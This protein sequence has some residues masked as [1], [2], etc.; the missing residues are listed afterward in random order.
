M[1]PI[2]VEAVEWWGPNF[3][4][5]EEFVG[6]DAELRDHRL[7]IATREGPLWANPHDWIIKSASGKFMVCPPETFEEA[8]KALEQ[9][10]ED[11]EGE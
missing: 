7:V 3:D 5:I 9:S 1:R 6:G 8:Y 4:E 11:K 10:G 2:I